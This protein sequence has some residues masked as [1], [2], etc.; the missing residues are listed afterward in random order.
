[1][2]Q[3]AGIPDVDKLNLIQEEKEFVS[4]LFKDSCAYL[5]EIIGNVIGF[6]EYNRIPYNKLK[7]GL[8]I[9][10]GLKPVESKD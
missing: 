7:H 8:S 5:K 9:L 2:Y 1:M 6:Y 10:S 3:L 4:K